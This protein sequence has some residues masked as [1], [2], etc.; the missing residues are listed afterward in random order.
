MGN[1]RERGIIYLLTNTVNDKQYIGQTIYL[2]R[3][4][5]EH[6]KGM[7]QIIDRA[8]DKYGWEKFNLE[9]LEDSIPEDKLSGKEREYIKKYNTF[10]GEGYNLREGG[11][12]YI[13]RANPFYGKRHTKE[14][15]IKMSENSSDLTPKEVREIKLM[16]RGNNNLTQNDL[17]DEF[18][19]AQYNISRIICG[20]RWGHI[21]IN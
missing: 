7:E 8:I 15:K 4:M 6:R 9:I 14:T 19:T 12:D 17:A 13:G 11:T 18:D 5:S 2:N 10:L 3:R 16:Y 1:S 20:K 21:T